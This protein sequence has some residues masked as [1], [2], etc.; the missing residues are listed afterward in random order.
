M[1]ESL[2][3]MNPQSPA[4]GDAALDVKVIPSEAVPRATSV[5]SISNAF[6]LSNFTVTPGSIVN[7]TPDAT[8]T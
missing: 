1:L 8:V 4:A 2:N 6:P 3:L 7:V 5:P